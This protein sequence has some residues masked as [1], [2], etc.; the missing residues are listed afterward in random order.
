MRLLCNAQNV[1]IY[2]DLCAM[3]HIFQFVC[4]FAQR[5][6]GR[7]TVMLLASC[8]REERKNPCCWIAADDTN[9]DFHD[10]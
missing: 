4:N 8:S 7:Y 1:I 6:T 9:H 5:N 3:C 2:H 10:M